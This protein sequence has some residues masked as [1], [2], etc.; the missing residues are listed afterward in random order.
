M[1]FGGA[2][3]EDGG[4]PGS[5]V[6]HLLRDWR[7]WQLE[8]RQSVVND[9]VMVCALVPK[10]QLKDAFLVV[11]SLREYLLQS[12]RMLSDGGCGSQEPAV[13]EEALPQ[14]VGL[15]A[16]LSP[17]ARRSPWIHVRRPGPSVNLLLE[18]FLS[19]CLFLYKFLPEQRS[20][21]RREERV[22][23]LHAW[24]VSGQR[25]LPAEIAIKTVVA[26]HLIACICFEA[27]RRVVSFRSL[28]SSRRLVLSQCLILMHLQ[29]R[30]LKV[31]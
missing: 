1:H 22:L 24:H 11:C 7:R 20:R 6:C 15:Q 17:E 12:L 31:D 8:H 4:P 5:V 30:N 21:G 18:Y 2:F 29:G 27:S 19:I 9:N 25:V 16:L 10:S 13:T 28:L 23:E 3:L 14:A 26:G